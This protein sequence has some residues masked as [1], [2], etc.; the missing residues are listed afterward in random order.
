MVRRFKTLGR[1]IKGEWDRISESM[2]VGRGVPI[3]V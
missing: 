3:G 2:S 1:E